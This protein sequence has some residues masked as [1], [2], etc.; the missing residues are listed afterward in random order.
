[1]IVDANVLVSA[2]LGR[3]LPLIVELRA[4][5][6]DVLMPSHQYLESRL[7]AGRKGGW[8]PDDFDAIAG[9]VVEVLSLDGYIDQEDVAR[10]RLGVRGQPDWP[11]LAAALAFD[12]DIWSNDRDFFGVGVPIWTT[13]NVQFVRSDMKR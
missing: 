7:M 13:A 9:A 10:A 1:M 11:V 2:F 6:V 8:S 3:S 12:H 4:R 5:G